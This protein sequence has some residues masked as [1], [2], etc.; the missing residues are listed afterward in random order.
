MGLVVER[1]D[2]RLYQWCMSNIVNDNVVKSVKFLSNLSC[3]W[4][5]DCAAS[6]L[7]LNRDSF[8]VSYWVLLA[9]SNNRQG[10]GL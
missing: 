1:C 2:I 7:G 3:S 8:P 10:L 4:I 6:A 9:N 5:G